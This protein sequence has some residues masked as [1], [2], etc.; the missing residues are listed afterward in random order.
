ML[1]NIELTVKNQ[2]II[3]KDNMKISLYITMIWKSQNFIYLIYFV[4]LQSRTLLESI[5]SMTL[6][7]VLNVLP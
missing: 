6:C 4:I 3:N 5:V 1:W 7:D 2:N